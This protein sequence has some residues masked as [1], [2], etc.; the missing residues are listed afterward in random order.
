MLSFVA[1]AYPTSRPTPFFAAFDGSL[2]FSPCTAPQPSLFAF[3]TIATLLPASPFVAEPSM[4]SWDGKTAPVCTLATFAV[5]VA[6]PASP[7]LSTTSA[8]PSL[9]LSPSSSSLASSAPSS[10]FSAAEST[11][12]RSSTPEPVDL[13]SLDCPSGPSHIIDDRLPCFIAYAAPSPRKTTPAAH[14]PASKTSFSRSPARVASCTPPAPFFRPY[15]LGTSVDGITEMPARR[16]PQTRQ[17][18]RA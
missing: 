13:S 8:A 2:S 10:L 18:W 7:C 5:E 16:F 15:T 6:V 14:R 12:S 9:R 11:S 3:C 4:E 17:P 1:A